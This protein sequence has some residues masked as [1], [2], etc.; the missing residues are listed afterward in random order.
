MVYFLGALAKV[1][2]ASISFVLF[3]RL[4]VGME[5]L[6]SYWTDFH[7][8]CY[9]FFENQS[10]KEP[11]PVALRPDAGHGVLILEVSRSHTTT[12]HSG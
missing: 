4:S 12:H 9:V 8:I 6:G 1:R 7:E 2:I 10:R 5:Q 3:V 11:P